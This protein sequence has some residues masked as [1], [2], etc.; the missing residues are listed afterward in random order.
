MAARLQA[1]CSGGE[2]GGAVAC[3]W[4]EAHPEAIKACLDASERGRE[5]SW[6]ETQLHPSAAR[7]ARALCCGEVRAERA[8]R[9]CGVHEAL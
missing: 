3:C 2:L 9:D 7:A 8:P 1:A 4:D 5:N 6:Q